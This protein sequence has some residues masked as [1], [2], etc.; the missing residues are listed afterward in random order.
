MKGGDRGPAVS[1]EA[2]GES[3][4]VEAINHRELK[5][6]PKGKLPQAE[7]DALSRWVEMGAPWPAGRL[8]SK[9][10]PPP[11]DDRARNFWSFRPV[12]RP[13]LPKV[14]RGDWARTPIDGFILARLE[15]AGLAPAPP[16]AKTSLL[17]RVTYDLTGLPPTP[18][19]VDAFLADSSPDAYEKVV[20]RLL[21]SPRYGE[22]WARHWL[23]LVRYAET[24]GYEFDA[25]KPERLA[26]SRLRDRELQQR[27][28][29]RPLHQGAARRR[30]AG[31]GLRRG[32]DRHRLLPRW[33][34]GR[35]RPPT[36][37]R[38]PSTS[39]TTSS[40]RPARSSSA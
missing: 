19:E 30:R 2:P 38:R 18:E 25:P 9:V 15:A 36:S 23:D 39:W 6:P 31:A 14:A 16:A 12:I 21:A 17:R 1:L 27:Q 8:T 34:L 4:L 7:I 29:L 3:L 13:E 5:M 11:V 28:A 32:P 10:G 35:P 26:L 33:A 24:D 37:S 40:A 22:R 20:D